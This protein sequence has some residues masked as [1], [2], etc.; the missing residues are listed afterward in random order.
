MRGIYTKWRVDVCP[1]A[2]KRT[3]LSFEDAE[4]WCF[5]GMT[6]YR[7]DSWPHWH[8]GHCPSWKAVWLQTHMEDDTTYE[9]NSLSSADDYGAA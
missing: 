5:D 8:V 4:S 9:D 2:K 3:Y 6:P 1:I 7:C